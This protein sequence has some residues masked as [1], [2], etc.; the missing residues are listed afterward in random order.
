MPEDLDKCIKMFET[1]KMNYRF[2][3]LKPDYQ[4]AVR[5]C[6]SRTCHTNITPE[7]WINH[8]YDLLEFDERVK[9]I[10]NTNMTAEE[11]GKYIWELGGFCNERDSKH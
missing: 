9:V 5:R 11:M 6:Q 8:F 1:S 10:D 7:Y 4:T 2:F 3:L